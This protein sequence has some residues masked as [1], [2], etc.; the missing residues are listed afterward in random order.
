MSMI[1]EFVN[2]LREKSELFSRSDFAVA[3]IAK[4][5]KDCADI[6]EQLSEKLSEVNLSEN[7]TS[8]IPCEEKLPEDN[9]LYEYYESVIVTLDNGR[10]VEGCYINKD[11]EWWV[12][13]VDG[14]HYSINA[15]GHVIAWMP[16]PEPFKGE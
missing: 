4:D 5:Y 16:L 6:I 14:E 8:W 2:R 12:D 13:D 1:K 10:V 9:P 3:G 11:K 15:T 7:L